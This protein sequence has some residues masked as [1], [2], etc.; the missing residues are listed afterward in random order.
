[1]NGIWKSLYVNDCHRKSTTEISLIC[2]RDVGLM[3]YRI[4]SIARS[5]L[6]GHQLE[7]KNMKKLRIKVRKK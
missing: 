5:S 2:L 6:D 7:E 4:R 3:R 1:M